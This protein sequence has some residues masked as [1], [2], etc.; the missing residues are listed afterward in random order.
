MK[1]SLSIPLN[2]FTS[3][4]KKFK[5]LWGVEIKWSNRYFDKPQELNSL[6]QFCIANDFKKALVTSLDQYGVKEIGDLRF[7]FVP[8]SL[9]AYNIGEN[10]LRTK[11]TAYLAF[12]IISSYP[13]K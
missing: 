5:S 3:D 9:Y 7:T 1:Y 4:D 6:I 10:T 8:S 12:E 2:A 13:R 11:N